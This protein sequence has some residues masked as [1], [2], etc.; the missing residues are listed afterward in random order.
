R[1]SGSFNVTITAVSNAKPP[2]ITAPKKVTEEATGPA[3]AAVTFTASAID[4][5]DGVIAVSCSP[6]SG[7]IFPLGETD[8]TCSAMNA[9]GKSASA[10]IAVTVRDTKA[11]KLTLPGHQVVE[12]TSAAGMAVS[13]VA[14]ADDVVDGS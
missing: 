2:K 6:A 3:G 14:T 10:I 8:V 4:P 7:S 9:A 1:A 11:P 12:A 5:V 13:L